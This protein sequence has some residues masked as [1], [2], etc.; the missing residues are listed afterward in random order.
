M[1]GEKFVKTETLSPFLGMWLAI[2]VLTPVGIFFTYKAMNDSQLFNKD[3]YLNFYRKV[4]SIF[5]VKKRATL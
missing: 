4:K 3:L 2:I 5:S 1:F